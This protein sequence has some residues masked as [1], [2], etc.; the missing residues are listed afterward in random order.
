MPARTGRLVAALLA[1]VALLA[2]GLAL[3]RPAPPPP[4][5]RP[6]AGDTVTPEIMFVGEW[7][8]GMS[9]FIN[10]RLRA[11]GCEG[12]P[13]AFLRNVEVPEDFVPRL[14]LVFY[15]GDD[16]LTTAE[17]LVIERTC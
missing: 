10:L 2:A 7:S 6:A 9:A 11:E 12:E 16:E 13:E 15:R 14:R 3:W 1:G 8:A 4:V 5:P 17:G